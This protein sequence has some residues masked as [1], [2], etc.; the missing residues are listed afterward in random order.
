MDYKK[1]WMSV[2]HVCVYL[3]VFQCVCVRVC[4]YVCVYEGMRGV[5]VEMTQA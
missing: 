4:V 5:C 1:Y 2:Q 3:C